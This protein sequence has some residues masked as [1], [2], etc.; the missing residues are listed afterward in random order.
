[1]VV[2]PRLTFVSHFEDLPDPRQ[3]WKVTYPLIE[4][5]LLVLCGVICGADGWVEVATFGK[6]R[7]EYLRQ[8]LPFEKGTPSHDTLGDLFSRLDPAE[9]QRCFTAW[10]E[11]LQTG[12]KGVV[13][14]DGKTLRHSFDEGHDAIHVVSAW[15]SRQELI[16][17][18]E[19]V[20]DKSNEIKAVPKL[21]DL[22]A[23]TGALVTLD[24]M[25]CQKDI[26]KKIRDKEADYILALK[27]NQPNLFKDVT[28]FLD[29]Q[30][31]AGQVSASQSR[32]AGHGRIE[33]REC[34][35]SNDVEWLQSLHPAWKDL[36]S[37]GMIRA[38]RT[39]KKTGKTSSEER[40]YISS[41]KEP[42]PEEFE[43][44]V[45]LHWGV[46]N[47]VH[48]VM[49]VIFGSDDCRIRQDYAPQNF[50]TIQQMAINLVRKVKKGKLSIRC[51]RLTAALMPEFLTEVLQGA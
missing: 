29:K 51:K 20:A 21:L 12:L 6:A 18:Q 48:W 31:Q 19:K 35:V 10:V 43:A 13:A 24:A 47:K 40:Y 23:L 30:I 25:G 37:I 38:H 34:F 16:L 26:A 45:R 33:L 5:L 14:I 50:A 41:L 1:M 22:L 15:S 3:L 49:D 9:F 8:F 36:N 39:I 7:L 27:E 46:E 32:D 11:S 2:E 4:I 17:G 28:Q 44:A 42:K